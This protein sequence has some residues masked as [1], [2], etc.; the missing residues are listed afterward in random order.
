MLAE[1]VRL[2]GRTVA[3]A[4]FPCSIGDG[5][6]PREESVQGEVRRRR[7]QRARQEPE[8]D[9]M[10]LTSE[11]NAVIKPNATMVPYRLS[12]RLDLAAIEPLLL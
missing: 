7:D 1:D 8:R 9:R 12:R 2:S 4:C 10:A 5:S 3:Q 6:R 11:E